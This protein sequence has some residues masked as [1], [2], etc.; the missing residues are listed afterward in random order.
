[1]PLR[2]AARVSRGFT[3]VELIAVISLLAVLSAVAI[4]RSVK[5]SSFEAAVASAFLLEELRFARRLAVNRQDVAVTLRLTLT[6]SAWQ[7]QV[8]GDGFTT[9]RARE[10]DRTNATLTGDAVAL[11]TGEVLTLVYDGLGNVTAA[12]IAGTGL[13]PADG[14]PVVL[15][16]ESSR[17][18]C[19]YPSGYVTGEGCV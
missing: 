2:P 4:S 7:V 19:I 6:A 3:I 17:T 13:T 14:V 18:L 9:L 8:L 12:D 11:N 16:A 15:T 10:A 1:M 5:P